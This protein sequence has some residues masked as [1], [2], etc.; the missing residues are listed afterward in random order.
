MTVA[1]WVKLFAGF[2]V[3][4]AVLEVMARSF[5]STRGEYGI[6][7]AIA[8]VAVLIVSERLMFGR[9]TRSAISFLGF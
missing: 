7:I 5:A 4:Y 1:A 3:A 8:V 2:L 6:P 9:G